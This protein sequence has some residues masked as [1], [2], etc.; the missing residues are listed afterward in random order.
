MLNVW[1]IAL[2]ETSPPSRILEDIVQSIAC[3]ISKPLV[4]AEVHCEE[5]EF[6]P[7][8]RHNAD[9][10]LQFTDASH[11]CVDLPEKRSSRQGVEFL[12]DSLLVLIKE[13]LMVFESVRLTPERADKDPCHLGRLQYLANI[14]QQGSINAHQICRIDL[15]SFIEHAAN[16]VRVW[17]EYFHDLLELIRDV[18]LMRVKSKKNKVRSVCHP[19][20]YLCKIVISAN[21]LLA[22][23]KHTRCVNEGDL[24]QYVSG[25]N[26]CLKTAQEA[27]PET[28]KALVRQLRQH[29][30]CIALDHLLFRTVHN[31]HELI[32]ARLGPDIEMRAVCASQPPH[33]G[34]LSCA[35]LADKQHLWSG[36][37]FFRCDWRC[38]EMRIERTFLSW[39]HLLLV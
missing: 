7:Q 29:S 35:V 36:L 25:V 17:S 11:K 12:Q 21:A 16:S 27:R 6:R 20:A 18:K 39:Q 2:A 26:Q 1:Q 22:S 4:G 31:S 15:V 33:H 19:S 8:L 34:S 37:K 23:G 3:P 32:G 38:A 14:P 10:G 5:R 24:T 30:C 9:M 28:G 13:L